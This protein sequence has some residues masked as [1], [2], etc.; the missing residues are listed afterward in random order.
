MKVCTLRKILNPLERETETLEFIFNETYK[1][2]LHKYGSITISLDK[3][4]EVYGDCEKGNEYCYSFITRMLKDNGYELKLVSEENET[5]EYILT[6][7]NRHP[8]YEG[9]LKVELPKDKTERIN[10]Y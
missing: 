2:A 10:L 1:L 4:Q 9:V 6:W 5:I 8:L 3:S 7:D